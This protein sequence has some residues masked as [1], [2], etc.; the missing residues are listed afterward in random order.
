MLRRPP[1]VAV[2]PPAPA[3][4]EEPGADRRRRRIGGPALTAL[5]LLVALAF[6]SIAVLRVIGIDS[7]D[8]NAFTVS[9]LALTPY[10]APAG[11]LLFLVAFGLRRRIIA[12]GVLLMTASMVVLVLPRVLPNDQPV[13]RGEHVRVLSANLYEGRAD[14]ASLVKLV[15]D[16]NIDVLTVPE[17][18]EQGLS[19]LDAAGLAELLPNRVVDPGAGAGGSGIL[20]RYEVRRTVLVDGA[21]PAEPSAV[22][23]LPGRN[24]IE[25]LAVH[26]Q[27]A[28]HGEAGAWSRALASLPAATPSRVRVLAGDFNASQ[29]HAAFRAVLDL[30]YVD[31]AEQTGDGLIPTWS[32]WPFGPPVTI[33]HVL[34][35]HRSAVRG[36]AVPHLPGSDHNAVFADIQLPN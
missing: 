17:L 24:D 26:V 34:V 4:E 8:G 7:I 20:S 22:V 14:P 25:I 31:A 1:R 32:S 11:L 5:L 36:F 35:D 33:D 19:E 15:R 30:G 12:L 3:P 23:D 6:L 13:A 16:N 18:T 21:A 9:A 29:D 27:A 28:V 10:V 2:E